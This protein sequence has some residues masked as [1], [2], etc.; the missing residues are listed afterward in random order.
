MEFQADQLLSIIQDEQ[1][2]RAQPQPQ[3]EVGPKKRVRLQEKVRALQSRIKELEMEVETERAA[4]AKIEEQRADLTNEVEEVS[5][6]MKKAGGASAI[7]VGVNEV[8]E[9]KVQELGCN[10]KGIIIEPAKIA[11]HLRDE[12]GS[13]NE[14]LVREKRKHEESNFTAEIFY[15]RDTY[16]E[17]LA[18][19]KT[20]KKENEN[21]RQE[22]TNLTGRLQE[23]AKTSHDL[24]TK[25][26]EYINRMRIRP[27]IPLPLFSPTQPSLGPAAFP[28]RPPPRIMTCFRCNGPNH[29]YRRCTG[30]PQ[31]PFSYGQPFGRR[32][33]DCRR[34]PSRSTNHPKRT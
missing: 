32:T 16:K 21:L 2:L 4:R 10:L 31:G 6:K 27:T 14:A 19:L 9:A 3:K 1:P 7:Q 30:H 11:A 20:L 8:Q 29:S 15:V 22:I 34:V 5:E 28:F 23:T 17:V 13:T 25:M 12:Q 24:V 26:E 18:E 33:F